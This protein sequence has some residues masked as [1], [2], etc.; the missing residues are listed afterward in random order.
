M[1]ATRYKRIKNYYVS[2]SPVTAQGDLLDWDR[3]TAERLYKYVAEYK[4]PDEILE[5]IYKLKIGGKFIHSENTIGG[6]TM[7]YTRIERHARRG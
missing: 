4:L 5:G 2:M 1:H 7:Y 3:E 6:G